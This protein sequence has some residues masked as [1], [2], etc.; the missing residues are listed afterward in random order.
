MAAMSFVARLPC[1]L[2]AYG[3]FEGIDWCFLFWRRLRSTSTRQKSAEELVWNE[4]DIP[5]P[6]CF[7]F[8]PFFISVF[9][10]STRK[11]LCHWFFI[12]SQSCCARQAFDKVYARKHFAKIFIQRFAIQF[13]FASQHRSTLR[14]YICRCVCKLCD[15]FFRSLFGFSDCMR[16]WTAQML[17]AE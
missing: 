15:R 3:W 11:S 16:H 9:I 14:N 13:R 1:V 12:S 6:A 7:P 2:N 17:A 4:S 5:A 8:F 10:F